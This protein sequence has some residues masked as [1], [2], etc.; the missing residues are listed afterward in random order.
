MR[1]ECSVFAEYANE[2]SK[3]CGKKYAE[4]KSK[5]DLQG[6]KNWFKKTRFTSDRLEEA[7]EKQ[8]KTEKE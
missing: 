1:S 8:T 4:Y 6:F 5:N 3:Q 7:Y 2:W